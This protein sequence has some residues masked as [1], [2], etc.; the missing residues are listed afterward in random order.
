MCVIN[1]FIR[2]VQRRGRTNGGHLFPALGVR[3]SSW[4]KEI[5]VG[6]LKNTW[7]LTNKRGKKFSRKW[8]Q[9]VQGDEVRKAP[10]SN[11]K[12]AQVP[13]AVG[14]WGWKGVRNRIVTQGPEEF[15]FVSCAM[16]E[17]QM[18]W[19]I[20]EGV[21]ECL[22]D[23]GRLSWVLVWAIPKLSGLKQPTSIFS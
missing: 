12:T 7:K 15:G 2:K 4:K 21:G 10:G 22:I 6:I 1:T 17:V 14:R 13:C 8:E 19:G 23:E 11:G 16:R 5:W 20:E 3:E 18:G 9:Y